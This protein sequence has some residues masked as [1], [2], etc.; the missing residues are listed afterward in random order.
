[1]EGERGV[2]L[3]PETRAIGCVRSLFCRHRT[4]G[5]QEFQL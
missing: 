4:G 2:D 1:V 5:E 3:L